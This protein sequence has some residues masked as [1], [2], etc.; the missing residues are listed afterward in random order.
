MKLIDGSY[1]CDVCGQLREPRYVRGWILDDDGG[2]REVEPQYA[3]EKHV[4]VVCEV[5]GVFLLGMPALAPASGSGEYRGLHQAARRVG[6]SR[7]DETA[8]AMSGDRGHTDPAS[9]RDADDAPNELAGRNFVSVFPFSSWS[10]S[11]RWRCSSD[12]SAHTTDRSR[13]LARDGFDVTEILRVVRLLRPYWRSVAQSLLVAALVLVLQIPGPYFTKILIDDA[14]P[15]G[16]LSL[17]SFALILGAGLSIG[18]GGISFMSGYF[19]Q[20]VG[21]SMGLRFQTLFYQHV[22]SLDFSFFDSR[23][24]GEILARFGDMRSS[25]TSVLQIV[26]TF[27]MNGLQLLIFP[28]ILVLINWQLALISLAVLPFDTLLVLVSSRYLRRLSLQLA[29]LSAELTAR[30]VE[31]LGGM[32]TIQALGLESRVYERLRALL[33][34]TAAVRMRSALVAGTSSYAATLIRAGARSPMAGMAGHRS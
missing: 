15:N 29:E 4:C 28:P 7:Q 8:C 32:R 17:M 34:R 3:E 33:V 30:N 1:R 23:E 16:D 27:I 19:G 12:S 11:R 21:T 22:Q 26:S 2:E 10:R 20:C 31:S 13:R 18:V 5:R 9:R 6:N 24:T 25:I 14:Y